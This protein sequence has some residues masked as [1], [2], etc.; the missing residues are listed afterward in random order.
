MKKNIF[1]TSLCS[2]EESL[3]FNRLV[4][5]ALSNELIYVSKSAR[6]LK[7]PIEKVRE[8]FAILSACK[9]NQQRQSETFKIQEL[10]LPVYHAL[11]LEVEEHFWKV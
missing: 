11:C 3:R 10:H 9:V 5:N 8:D 6:L 2:K 1:Q 4:Y 7:Q